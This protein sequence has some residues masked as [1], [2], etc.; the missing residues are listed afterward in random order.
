[1]LEK[2]FK[3]FDIIEFFLKDYK[4][5]K[6]KK[7]LNFLEKK[8][9]K[10][11]SQEK[12]QLYIYEE[13]KKYEEK[14]IK[15]FQSEREKIYNEI[16]DFKI[17]SNTLLTLKGVEIDILNQKKNL[18]NLFGI[19]RNR[20]KTPIFYFDKNYNIIPIGIDK[21]FNIFISDL[22][23]GLY[24]INS[25]NTPRFYKGK[26]ALFL[27]PDYFIDL[28]I[29]TNTKT[30]FADSKTANLIYNNVVDYKLTHPKKIIDIVGF[31]RKYW[32]FFAIGILFIV[33]YS[34]GQLDKIFQKS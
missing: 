4:L 34:T 2:I 20:Y 24:I 21:E 25:N 17:N 3:P 18:L 16:R 29:D 26:R 5:Y 10:E 27:H 14:I 28:D 8:I 30:F 19:A 13:L 1:M 9:N 6:L 32:V 15:S 33:L 7:E 31:I 11:T 23:K 22:K 12:L